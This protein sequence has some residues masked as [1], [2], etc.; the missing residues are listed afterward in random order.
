MLLFYAYKSFNRSFHQQLGGFKMAAICLQFRLVARPVVNYYVPAALYYG[1]VEIL[2]R[3]NHGDGQFRKFV[4]I[5][6]VILLKS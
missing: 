2:C 3:Q 5:N 1:R 6:F 4:C